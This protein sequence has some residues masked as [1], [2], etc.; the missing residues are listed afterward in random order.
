MN[1]AVVALIFLLAAIVLGFVR[2][3]NVG[4]VCLGLAFILGRIGNVPTRTILGGFPGNLFLTLLGTM[5]FFS[6]LQENN[7]LELLSKKIVSLVGTKTFF[8]PVIIYAASFLLSAAGP[9]AISVQAVMIIFAVS[10][11]V[12]MN[13]SPILMGGMAILGAVGGTASP[14]ALTGILVR[15]LTAGANITGLDM[16]VF[17]GVSVVNFICAVVL[18]IVYGGYKLRSDSS[19]STGVIPAFNGSQKICTLALLAMIILVVGFQ[20]DVGLISFMLALILM[21][22]GIVNEKAAMKL[23]PWSVLIL[24]CGVNVLMTVTKAMGGID[25]LASILASMMNETTATPIIGLTAGIMSWFSSANGVVF[26]TLIPTVPDIVA[27]VGGNVTALQ[28]IVSIVAAACVAG[29]SPLSTG[30]S[31]VLASYTQETNA[32]DKEQASLFAKLFG[33]SFMVVM[34]VVIFALL[35]GFRLFS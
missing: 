8:I 28:M 31:L 2:K 15:D 12:Q 24:I 34:V 32:S 16:P 9:G 14:I 25:L 22:M 30:G 7:T 3:M 19:V 35:G 1:L 21:L 13:A 18:Y 20:Y 29:I 11:S 4:L 33:T 5:F 6:L 17:I 10:L 23:V 26:P 27:N